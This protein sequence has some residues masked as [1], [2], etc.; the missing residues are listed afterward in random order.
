MSHKDRTEPLTNVTELR[1][2][3]VTY[4]R[5]IGHVIGVMRRF[6][7]RLVAHAWVAWHDTDKV[8]LV[9]PFS[10]AAENIYAQIGATP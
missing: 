2:W 5:P 7:F 9:R 3:C 4:E 10:W 1:G 8:Y 6:R